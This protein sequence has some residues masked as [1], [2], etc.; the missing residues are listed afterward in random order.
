MQTMSLLASASL[1]SLYPLPPAYIPL[2]QDLQVCL[3]G[4]QPLR[5]AEGARAL[6][7][8]GGDTKAGVVTWG[9]N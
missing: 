7:Q 4:L 3:D 1:T 2:A 9:H 8:V 6:D 5:W